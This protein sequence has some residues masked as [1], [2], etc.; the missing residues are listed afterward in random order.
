MNLYLVRNA[1]GTPVWIAHED[2]EMRI[3]TYMQNT[4]KFHLNQGLYRD[5]YF[6]HA[7]TYAPISV[8]TALEQIAEGVGKLDTRT[9]GHLVKR[10]EADPAAR[11]IEDVLGST[12]V[13]TV[14][15]QAA[16]R[17][18]A[19][20]QAPAGTWMTWKSY[21]RADKQLAHV[22]ANNLRNGKIKII[23]KLGPVDARLEDDANDTVNVLVARKRSQTA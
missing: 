6:E 17:A 15:Q 2:N 18:K 8:D 13:P 3:W 10:F 22:A 20:E 14:R 19:L 21:R 9:L 4:G 16:A 23:N 12:P 11:T 7:N 1:A 5:F